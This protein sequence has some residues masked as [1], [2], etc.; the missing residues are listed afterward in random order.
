[1]LRTCDRAFRHR[2]PRIEAP[3]ERSTELGLLLPPNH[4]VLHVDLTIPA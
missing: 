2:M 3:A 4:T 1:M